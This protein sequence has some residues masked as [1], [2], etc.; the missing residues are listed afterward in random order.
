LRKQC[1]EML[2]LE[3]K[4]QLIEKIESTDDNAI[5]EEVYRILDIGEDNFGIYQLSSE[6]R[7]AVD[8]GLEDIKNGR[9][10]SHD[11]AKKEIEEWF[12]K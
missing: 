10:I 2:T 7:L 6:Q 8:A 4:K 9:V 1:F 3:L 5:L 11:E 12:S